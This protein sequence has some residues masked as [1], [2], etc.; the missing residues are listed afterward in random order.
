MSEG[1]DALPLGNG[2]IRLI[3]EENE[4]DFFLA[5]HTPMRWVH[6]SSHGHNVITHNLL[7]HVS[8][9]LIAGVE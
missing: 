2:V 4:N 9:I 6:L 1:R 3:S 8:S 7:T 5:N